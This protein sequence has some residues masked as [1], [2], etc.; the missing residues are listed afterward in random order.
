M[1]FDGSFV[2]VVKSIGLIQRDPPFFASRRMKNGGR[3][4]RQGWKES[5]GGT[6]RS[7]KPG[8]SVGGC[9]I[10]PAPPLSPPASFDFSF[11]CT[12]ASARASGQFEITLSP[13][14]CVQS[15]L[16]FKSSLARP[17][18]SLCHSCRSTGIRN[19]ENSSSV[20]PTTD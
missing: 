5:V 14:Q 18:S 19:T 4:G 10:H 7:R 1:R 20:D 6:D 11:P 2:G 13:S 15:K 17:S 3:D 16:Q 8:V 12:R 9:R